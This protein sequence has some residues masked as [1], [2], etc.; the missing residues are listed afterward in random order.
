M[1][2]VI[3]LMPLQPRTTTTS[4]FLPLRQPR[5]HHTHLA[6]PRRAC[7]ARGPGGRPGDLGCPFQRATRTTASCTGWRAL[8]PPL[9]PRP[10]QARLVPISH[11]RP[12]EEP[13]AACLLSYDV[14]PCPWH[15]CGGRD[16]PH[17]STRALAGA[18]RR[19][20]GTPRDPHALTAARSLCALRQRTHVA[21][22][23]PTAPQWTGATPL[24]AQPWYHTGRELH[25]SAWAAGLFVAHSACQ[26]LHDAR[27]RSH[28]PHTTAYRTPPRLFT[29]PASIRALARAGGWPPAPRGGLAISVLFA[30]VHSLLAT[31]HHHTP[32]TP[33]PAD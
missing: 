2:P 31:Q 25:R 30:G 21:T 3:P 10:L 14:P 5:L 1:P 13:C 32:P 18:L 8:C 9:S 33:A 29:P 11:Q 16:A 6:L 12:H 24:I 26:H 27:P 19:S 7:W 4:T 17:A 23:S 20:Y 15:G 22:P 28:A